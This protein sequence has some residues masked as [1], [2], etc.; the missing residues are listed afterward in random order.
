MTFDVQFH[1]V[2]DT[3]ATIYSEYQDGI[4]FLVHMGR[5]CLWDNAPHRTPNDLR[6]T[7]LVPSM[8]Y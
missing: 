4:K 8:I 6:M 2:L 5:K 1:E 7:F 3:R